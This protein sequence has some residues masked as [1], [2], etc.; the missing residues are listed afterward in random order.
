[1]NGANPESS[2][3]KKC[4]KG[5]RVTSNLDIP[6]ASPSSKAKE[7]VEMASV[8]VNAIVAATEFVI[9]SWTMLTN[10]GGTVWEKPVPIAENKI[11]MQRRTAKRTCV[12]LT[13]FIIEIIQGTLSGLDLIQESTLHLG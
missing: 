1:M 4:L 7:P 8:E 3:L 12:I 13:G 11:A 9:V 6:R 2:R 5:K 10:A